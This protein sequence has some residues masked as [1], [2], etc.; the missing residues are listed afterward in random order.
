MNTEREYELIK[1]ESYYESGSG[2]HGNVHI[3]PLPGQSPFETSMRVECSKVLMDP[4]VHKVGT[5]FLIQAKITSRLG[6]TP[7]I[8]SSYA[9]PHKVITE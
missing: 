8:Y 5:K 3:R 1:V 7:F 6:G 4:R 9:W 2:L